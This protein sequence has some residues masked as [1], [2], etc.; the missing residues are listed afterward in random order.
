MKCKQV[1]MKL[2]RGCRVNKKWRCELTCWV[3]NW[4]LM[5]GVGTEATQS[6]KRFTWR[7]CCFSVR[8]NSLWPHGLQH[9]RLPCLSPSA[10]ACSNSWPLNQWCHPTIS[11][12]VLPFSSRLQSLKHQGLHELALHIS[13][14][15][16][17][18]H[19][20]LCNPWIAACQASLSI[21]NSWS[22]QKLMS[23]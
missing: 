8:S 10:G 14:V 18:S 4:R 21:T 12:S 11:S 20:Q 13:S 16:S 6:D 15:Q 23:I 22:L 3:G 5:S 2:I 9:T 1:E 19:I 7:G 17:L